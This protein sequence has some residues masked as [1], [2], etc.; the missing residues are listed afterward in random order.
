MTVIGIMESPYKLKS[1]SYKKSVPYLSN[2]Y[3]NTATTLLREK[4]GGRETIYKRLS[5]RGKQ[6]YKI[7]KNEYATIKH[8][9]KTSIYQD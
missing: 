4:K 6:L 1:N 5:R 3:N 8:S 2:N 7:F 9:L